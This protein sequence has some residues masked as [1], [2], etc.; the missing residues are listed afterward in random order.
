MS[1]YL[2]I[3]IYTALQPEGRAVDSRGGHWYFSLT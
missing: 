2:Y 1:I 3:Y